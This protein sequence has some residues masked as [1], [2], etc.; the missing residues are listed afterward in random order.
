MPSGTDAPANSWTTTP[1]SPRQQ[2]VQ[3]AML[4]QL[5]PATL[6]TKFEDIANAGHQGG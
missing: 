6:L 2:C 1:A 4:K 3:Q 5:D